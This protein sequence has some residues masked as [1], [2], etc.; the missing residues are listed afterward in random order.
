MTCIQ[1]FNALHIIRQDISTYSFSP[2][3]ST[4]V[5]KLESQ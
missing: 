3:S 1:N 2:Y 4:P 5:Q